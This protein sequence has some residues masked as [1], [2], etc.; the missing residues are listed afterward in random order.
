[1]KNWQ[2]QQAKAHFSELIKKAGN[3]GPQGITV[4]GKPEAIIISI[5]DF[6]KLVSKPKPS[7]VEFMRR[8]PLVGMRLNLKRDKSLCRDKNETGI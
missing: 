4:R 8:S 1:M 6:K 7:F 3:E 2:L 5:H